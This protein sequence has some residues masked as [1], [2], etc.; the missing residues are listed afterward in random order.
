MIEYDGDD[1]K[2]D[3]NRPVITIGVLM[4]MMGMFD[5]N[6]ERHAIVLIP[7]GDEIL[8]KRSPIKYFDSVIKEN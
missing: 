5:N 4:E 2:P 7:K 6:G 3:P 1:S 8:I